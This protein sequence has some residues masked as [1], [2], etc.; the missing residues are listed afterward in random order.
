MSIRKTIQVILMAATFL[1]ATAVQAQLGGICDSKINITSIKY[2]GKSGGDDQFEVKW[3]FEA[4]STCM[5]LG[6][7]EAKMPPA[8]QESFTVP[9]PSG[10]TVH[11]RLK[12]RGGG[13]DEGQ[14]TTNLIINAGG[15]VTTVVDVHRPLLALDPES[16]IVTITALSGG[17]TQKRAII[18]GSGLPELGTATQTF[19]T[20]T[21]YPN[22]LPTPAECFP[23][24]QVT[25]L[26]FAAG[27][28]TTS[29]SLTIAWNATTASA[30]CIS[31]GP[32]FI[33][34]SVHGNRTNRTRFS[35]NFETTQ[36]SGTPRT[37]T[38]Q[39]GASSS[40]VGQYK[41][42]VAVTKPFQSGIKAIRDVDF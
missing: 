16:C 1:S 12:R 29:D 8:Q 42:V 19:Q 40:P 38:I 7:A 39:L 36:A 9:A 30:Q 6:A 31:G 25:A 20:F 35:E 27:T 10:Y 18:T 41:V 32:L 5:K 22:A 37:A 28:G 2:L 11:V 13:I 21:I 4:A 3:N 26:T 23:D 14:K 24:V 15:N 34:I 33:T 17:G